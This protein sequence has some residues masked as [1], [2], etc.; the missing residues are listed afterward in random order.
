MYHEH[1]L[2]IEGINISGN[3]FTATSLHS[4]FQQLLFTLTMLL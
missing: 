2:V 1:Y 3:H 4:M